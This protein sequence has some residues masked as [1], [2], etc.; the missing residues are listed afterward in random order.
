MNKKKTIIAAAVLT[1]VLLVGGILAYFTDTEEQTNIFTIGNVDI[2]LTEAGWT[3]GS[4]VSDVWT[5]SSNTGDYSR[6]EALNLTPNAVIPKAPIVTNVGSNDAYVY[7][8]VLVPMDD[9]KTAAEALAGTAGANKELFTFTLNSGWR[10][11]SR[12]EVDANTD[13]VADYAEYIFVYA[14]GTHTGDSILKEEM[15]IL[16]KD[17]SATGT[18]T[19]AV[20]NNVTLIDLAEVPASTDLE[21]N[22]KAYAIQANNIDSA[23]TNAA[24]IYSLFAAQ[25]E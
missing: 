11:L 22:V 1:I 8:K 20:F 13:T 3:E 10:Q 12:T 5:A 19:P 17:G 4:F 9:A 25:G 23:K 24:Q 15:T 7:V 6:T 18:E 14:S 16:N 21:I 2:T